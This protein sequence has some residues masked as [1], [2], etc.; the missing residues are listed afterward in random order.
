MNGEDNV[1]DGEN[2]EDTEVDNQIRL[3]GGD[4]YLNLGSNILRSKVE[5]DGN[6]SPDEIATNLEE[7]CSVE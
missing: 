5:E 6:E 7:K 1:Y 4:S 2:F 3:D